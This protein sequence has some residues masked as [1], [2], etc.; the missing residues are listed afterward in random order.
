MNKK[1]CAMILELLEQGKIEDLKSNIQNKLNELKLKELNGSSYLS[2]LKKWNK[3][4][5][6][7]DIRPALQ[8]YSIQDLNDGYGDVQITTNSIVAF[9]MNKGYYL[10]LIKESSKEHTYPDLRGVVPAVDSMTEVT[11]NEQAYLNPVQLGKHTLYTINH[12]RYEINVELDNLKMAL[13]IL[14]ENV[15]IYVHDS[16]LKPILLENEKGRCM[17]CPIKVK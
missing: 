8:G 3:I 16:E 14:G 11:F 4:L 15:K 9:I 10:D 6:K 12:S 7:P 13:N 2:N 1:E 5:S 17:I